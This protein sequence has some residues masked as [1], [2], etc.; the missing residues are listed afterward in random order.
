MRPAAEESLRGCWHAPRLLN[1]LSVTRIFQEASSR[2]ATAGG[3]DSQAHCTG[4]GTL[5]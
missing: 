1:A 4:Q 5:Q 3:G 2:A